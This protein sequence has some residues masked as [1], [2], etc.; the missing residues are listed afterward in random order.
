MS[1][2]NQTLLCFSLAEH[3]FA[4]P[5]ER[6]EK[7]MWAVAVT[8][9]PDSTALV[10]GMI[11]FHG[12]VI[13]VVSLRIRFG[14]QAKPINEND[15]FIICTFRTKK[16]AIVVDQ[17]DEVINPSNEEI[18]DVEMPLANDLMQKMKKSGLEMMHF[19][20]DKTGIVIIYDL[21]TLIGEDTILEIQELFDQLEK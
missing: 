11:D 21:E 7:V 12:E 8:I 19:L 9:I 17:V 18:N 15:R 6:V 20:R 14:L 3:R 1:V 10:H 2:N 5:I 4:I 13:P 16:I